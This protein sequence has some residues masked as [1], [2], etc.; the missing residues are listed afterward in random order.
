MVELTT[1]ANAWVRRFHPSPAAS[2]RLA[3]FPHAGGAASTFHQLSARLAPAVEG[4]SL[5]YPGRHDRRAEPFLTDVRSMA[6]MAYEALRPWVRP[7]DGSAPALFGHSMGAIVA[8]EVALRMEAAGTAPAH[9][10]VSGRRA[11]S[12]YR[13]ERV[14]LRDDAGLVE[15]ILSLG[16]TEPEALADASLLQLILPPVRNDYTAIET[17]RCPPGVALR[18]TPI[19]AL[20]GDADPKVTLEEARAW[21]GHTA[22]GFELEVFEG[23]GHFYLAERQDEV[24][25]TVT[26]QLGVSPVVA[27]G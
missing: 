16:G 19:T 18:H 20:A 1:T 24:V 5:Q 8:F 27:A 21:A 9:L 13:D 3:C 4:L 15:E 26:R 2:R 25:S 23:G 11:P 12:T 17:Y 6:D 7:G 14:H 10:F 22:A